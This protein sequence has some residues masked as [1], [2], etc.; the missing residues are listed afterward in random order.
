MIKIILEDD[1]EIN[2]DLFEEV[3]P[4]TVANFK[5]LVENNYYDGVIFHRIIPHFVIQTGGFTIKDN[6][7]VMKE[8]VKPIHGEFLANGF[9]NKLPHTKGVVSMARTNEFNSASSQFFI[10][11]EDCPHL[12]GNYAAFGKVKD[13]SSMAIAVELSEAPRDYRDFPLY[14]VM[15]KKVIIVD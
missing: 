6:E 10:C 7:I 15:I 4:E 13:D 1:R 9:D 3:A 14:P 12:D 5:N 8:H 11:V 2:I